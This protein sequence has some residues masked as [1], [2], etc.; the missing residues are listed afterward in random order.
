VTGRAVEASA[1]G[2]LDFGAVL[3]GAAIA[4]PN[5]LRSRIAANEASAVGA[6]RTVETAQIAYRGVY[7]QRGFAHDLASLGTD[8]IRSNAP[9]ADHAGFIDETLGGASCTAGAWCVK[10]GFRFS[11]AAVCKQKA[12]TEFV[13]VG[14]PVASNAGGR[15]FCSTSDGVIRSNTGPPLTAPVNVSECR[16]WS[17]IQ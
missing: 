8:P 17:P 16:A 13:V 5:L 4:I 6:L 3:V 11:L 14:T 9:S 15:S 1:N 2:A 12:C 7:P 10:S